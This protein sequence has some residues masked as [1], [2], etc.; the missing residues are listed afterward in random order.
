MDWFLR[1]AGEA[2]TS[3]REAARQERTGGP[4]PHL[5]KVPNLS[6]RFVGTDVDAMHDEHISLVEVSQ[7]L[8]SKV[9]VLEKLEAGVDRR[10]VAS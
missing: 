8:E 6:P 7:M 2:A 3:Q 9:Q 5:P 10:A 4:S 1:E